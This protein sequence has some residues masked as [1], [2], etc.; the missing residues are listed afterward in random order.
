[1]EKGIFV[2]IV[3][4]ADISLYSLQFLMD[5]QLLQSKKAK[6]MLREG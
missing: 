2:D 5:L 3:I 6:G 1:M 4:L